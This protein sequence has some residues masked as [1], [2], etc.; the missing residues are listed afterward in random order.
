M[1]KFKVWD[2]VAL[3]STPT[4]PATVKECAGTSIAVRFH[5]SGFH[6]KWALNKNGN[7]LFDTASF[8]LV[9][10]IDSVNPHE[11]ADQYYM[12]VTGEDCG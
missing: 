11:G 1:Y 6:N 5:H 8:K 10:S 9:Q 12:A 2:I 4:E 7:A 3:I